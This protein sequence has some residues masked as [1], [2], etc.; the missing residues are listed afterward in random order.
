MRQKVYVVAFILLAV[1]EIVNSD[2][3]I[4]DVTHCL[5]Y[6]LSTGQIVCNLNVCTRH[7]LKEWSMSLIVYP[8]QEI[9]YSVK[10]FSRLVEM[11]PVASV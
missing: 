9:N 7:I 10:R 1:L 3:G 4:V 2:V 8:V 11:N 5:N 6:Y